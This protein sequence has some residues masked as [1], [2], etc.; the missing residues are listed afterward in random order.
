MI[1]GNAR[2]YFLDSQDYFSQ[3]RAAALDAPEFICKLHADSIGHCSEL[4]MTSLVLVAPLL[5]PGQ[6]DE[7]D[8]RTLTH[9]RRVC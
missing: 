6:S 2:A 3:W 5:K 7:P 4:S 8:W 9:V 1:V